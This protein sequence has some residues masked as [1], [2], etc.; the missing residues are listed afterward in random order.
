[1]LCLNRGEIDTGPA[2]FTEEI[3]AVAAALRKAQGKDG[4]KGKVDKLPLDIWWGG[5]DG[6]VPRN[7]QGELRWSDE[8][9]AEW[10]N[11]SFAAHPG[12]IAFASHFV[13]DG[14]HSDLIMRAQGVGEVYLMIMAGSQYGA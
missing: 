5:Q 13:E 10:L 3:G 11:K 1:M 6:M 14:D 8:L 7:G 4:E 2:W 9:T 12:E